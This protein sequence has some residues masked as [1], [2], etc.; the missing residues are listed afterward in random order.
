M[1]L[2]Q[3]T[4]VL[5]VILPQL[6]SYCSYDVEHDLI[7]PYINALDALVSHRGQVSD[8]VILTT[9]LMIPIQEALEEIEPRYHSSEI[10]KIIVQLTANMALTRKMRERVRQI[11]LA[12]RHLQKPSADHKPRRRISP[13]A[14]LK[15]SYFADALDFFEIWSRK[16]EEQFDHVQ[17][18]RAR[19]GEWDQDAPVKDR[20]SRDE[21]VQTRRKRPAPRRKRKRKKRAPP[22]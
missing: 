4:E 17:L 18:W 2:M 22:Q 9:L 7:T 11:L 21:E 20:F 10:S 16:A 12:Q 5:N 13:K 14:M 19:A 8:S 3:E 6:A 1:K 15:R